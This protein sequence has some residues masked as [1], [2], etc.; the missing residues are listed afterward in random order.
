VK[1]KWKTKLN[2]DPIP[3]L[4]KSNPWTR[5][6]TMTDLLELDRKSKEVKSAYEDLITHP[7]VVQ[8]IDQAAMWFPQSITRHNVPD[9]SHYQMMM[10]IDFGLTAEHPKIKEIC[11]KA[12]SRLENDLFAVRQTLPQKGEGFTK[13]IPSVNEWHA[14]PCDSPLITAALLLSGFKNPAI[15]KN[16]EILKDYWKTE[17]GWFC[18]FF[19]VE[20][21]FKKYQTG[22]PMAGLMALQVF[23]LIPELKESVFSQNGYA[24]IRY[25]R[26]LAK[27]LYYFGRSKKFWTIKYPY[28]WYNA[29]YLADVLTRFESLRKE[30]LVRELIEWIIQS[31]DENGRFK[32]T[33]MF[34]VYKSWDFANKKEP[35]PWITLLC[36][37]ILK[38]FYV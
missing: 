8:L 23:S 28:I 20:D 9:L 38:R 2:G 34:M 5:Y 21:Q 30:D 4:L 26:D 13:P 22:C 14:M 19:F 6:R 12:V 27:S 11:T 16:I 24:P 18:H 32:P 33:S 35:S 7:N 29:L 1:D 36:C 10:L 37:R 25:H 17:R 3:W 31:Q 15:R